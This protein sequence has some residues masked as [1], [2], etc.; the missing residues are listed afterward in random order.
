VERDPDR[1]D[2]LAAMAAAALAASAAGL[3]GCARLLDWSA[4]RPGAARESMKPAGGSAPAGS[5]AGT[6]TSAATSS[7]GSSAP[8][9]GGA[10][11]AP[12]KPLERFDLSVARGHGP[13]A[14]T[15]AAIALLG[16]MG[17]F[18]KSGAT[19][20]VKPNLL[21]ARPPEDGVS[22]NPIVVGTIVAMCV[23]AGAKDVIVLDQPTSEPQST[24]QI[25]GIADATRKAGG[26]VKILTDR[27]FES[28]AIP[29]GRLLS[30]LPIVKD[31]FQADTFI[32][33]PIAKTH[34]LAGLTMAMKNLM[35][36]MGDPRSVMHTDFDQK[37]VDLNTLVKPH[38]VVLDATRI[39]FRNGPTGGGPQDTKHLDTVIA[40][41]S[42]VSVDAYGTTLFGMRPTDLAYLVNAHARGLGEID[43]KKLR[44]ARA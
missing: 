27:N 32:N 10:T 3:S 29:K 1:R 25:S 43:L 6:T 5:E 14:N 7:A 24:F 40:G 39:L 41:T 44:I 23:E 15:R 2:F 19:V 13:A 12:A 33:V 21:T 26:R 42:Q 34:S 35:G 20:V 28:V 30:S 11:G 17:A 38:L 16:G 8:A 4:G 22:T 31:V 36:I 37:I 18:V 9:A